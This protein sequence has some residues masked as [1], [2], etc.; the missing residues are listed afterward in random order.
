RSMASFSSRES[1]LVARKCAVEVMLACRKKDDSSF[2]DETLAALSQIILDALDCALKA[3]PFYSPSLQSF[4]DEA[5]EIR[6]EPNIAKFAYAF[7]I[8]MNELNGSIIGPARTRWPS[9]R[10][11]VDRTTAAAN[12]VTDEPRG[13]NERPPIQT[14]FLPPEQ[15]ATTVIEE[16]SILNRLLK[17]GVEEEDDAKHDLRSKTDLLES[18]F[19]TEMKAEI[20]LEL[21]EEEEKPLGLIEEPAVQMSSLLKAEDLEEIPFGMEVAHSKPAEYANF[22]LSFPPGTQ[23]PYCP[24]AVHDLVFLKIHMQASHPEMLTNMTHIYVCNGCA[25]A[26]AGVVR[27]LRHWNENDRCRSMGLRF[28]YGAAAGAMRRFLAARDARP[29]HV[30]ASSAAPTR[31]RRTTQLFKIVPVVKAPFLQPQTVKVAALAAKRPNKQ[32]LAAARAA[33]A[34]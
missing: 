11:S 13:L 26:S 18:M 14:A 31:K 9:R 30:A 1:L 12:L 20:K 34:A 10:R 19:P 23:C 7:A 27:M 24:K 2:R 8:L 22:H 16:D 29:P 25:F 3:Q 17:E 5:V 15:S 21:K 4:K 33:A 32:M 6:G 28:D